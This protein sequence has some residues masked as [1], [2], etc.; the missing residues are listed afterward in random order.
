M[1]RAIERSRDPVNKLKIEEKST[2]A[3]EQ[4][5][6]SE[7]SAGVGNCRVPE[8]ETGCSRVGNSRCPSRKPVVPESETPSSRVGNCRCTESETRGLQSRQLELESET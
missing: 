1:E 6:E 7:T 4:K 2:G 8:S 3:I 5:S